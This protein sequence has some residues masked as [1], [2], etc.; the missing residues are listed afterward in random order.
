MVLR[1]P[2]GE[3]AVR[4]STARGEPVEPPVAIGSRTL[5]AKLAG[6]FHLELLLGSQTSDHLLQKGLRLGFNRIGLQA[7]QWMG[8]DGHGQFGHSQGAALDFAQDLE[9]VGA[10]RNSGNTTAL[11]FY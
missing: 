3:R 4:F 9:A 11:Q 1:Q 6:P 2:H 10:N 5:Q 8:S 7:S